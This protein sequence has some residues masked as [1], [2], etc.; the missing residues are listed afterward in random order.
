MGRG[1]ERWGEEG[2]GE[3][4]V[5]SPAAY[6]AAASENEASL[7]VFPINCLF[8]KYDKHLGDKKGSEEEGRRG[9]QSRLIPPQS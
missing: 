4:Y 3:A 8:Y 5:K 6:L 9:G 7:I 2:R 1:G